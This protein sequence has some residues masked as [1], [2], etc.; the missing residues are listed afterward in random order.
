MSTPNT[1]KGRQQIKSRFVRNAIPTEK[2]FDDLIEAGLNQADDG[3]FKLPNEPLSLNPLR[4]T[5]DQAVLLFY[6]GPDAIDVAW[7][8][9]LSADSK[10]GFAL[11]NEKGVNF[12]IDS[13]NGN[14]GIGTTSAAAK[15]HVF[16]EV[17]TAASPSAGSLLLD[18]ED[19]GGK[20]SIVFRSKFNRLSDYAYIEYN[21]NNKDSVSPLFENESGLL[22]IGIQNDNDDHIALMPSGCVGIGTTSPAAK[23]HIFEVVGTAAASSAASLLIGHGNTGGQSSIVFRSKDNQE[24]D[25]AYIEY[26]ENNEVKD[27]TEPGKSGLLTIGIQNDYDDHIALMPSG[28]VGIGVVDPQA[29]LHITVPTKY[30]QESQDAPPE[31]DLNPL[32]YVEGFRIEFPFGSWSFQADGNLVKYGRSGNVI[33]QSASLGKGGKGWI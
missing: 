19:P 3:L 2:D 15:L 16:E 10:P 23:L 1:K 9:Q 8:I 6:D 4:Q 14:V 5:P 33:W 13:S 21:E 20:S 29:K 17:G 32:N 27:S 25:Y 31:P 12:I 28:S 26:K 22:T 11:A 7:Q 30:K 18:H 24:N